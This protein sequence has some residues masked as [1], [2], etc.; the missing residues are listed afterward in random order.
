[1][2][3]RTFTEQI[4]EVS[5]LSL[6][7]IKDF[8]AKGVAEFHG[9][10]FTLRRNKYGNILLSHGGYINHIESNA[11]RLERLASVADHIKSLEYAG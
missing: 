11:I 2:D 8:M 3:E 10:D 5:Q 4:Q 1:M 7:T 9:P 6:V